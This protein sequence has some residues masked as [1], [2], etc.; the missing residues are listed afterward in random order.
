MKNKQKWLKSKEKKQ[1]D[2]ITNY[3]KKLEALINK[4]GDHKGKEIFNELVKERFD[5]IIELTDEIN[6]NDLI[7]CFKGNS[8]RKRFDDFNYGK[9]FFKK[10]R[11]GEMKLRS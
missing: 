1:I 10:I 4:D 6:Q 2:A 5:T 9:N 11:S 8:T 3:N 7:Y